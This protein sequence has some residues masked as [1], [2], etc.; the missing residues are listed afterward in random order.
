ME[1]HKNKKKKLTI[2]FLFL[3]GLLLSCSKE[4]NDYEEMIRQ[5]SKAMSQDVSEIKIKTWAV[6]LSKWTEPNFFECHVNEFL[7]EDKINSPKKGSI[8]FIGSSSIVYWKT[9]KDDMS[10]LKILNR[11]FGGAHI[12]HVNYHLNEIV[13][14]YE[15]LGIVFFCGTNDLAALKTPQE[16]FK[17]FLI[18]LNSVKENLPNTKIFVIGVKPSTARYHLRKKE[19]TLNK[20]K[21]DLSKKEKN[22]FFID[23]WEAMLIDG[24]A[25]PDLFEEDGLHIN[26]K[27]YEIWKNKVKPLLMEHFAKQQS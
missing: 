12:S 11:G 26:Q 17:D 9:L 23:V 1:M 3:L 21:F 14:P 2:L 24:K 19:L 4:I 13:L 15:P 5:E 16:V 7:E 8:L 10:P 27:G 6:F 25:N 20:L 18:F 22:L